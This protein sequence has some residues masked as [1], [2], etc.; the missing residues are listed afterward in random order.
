[1][2]INYIVKIFDHMNIKGPINC[3]EQLHVYSVEYTC[4]HQ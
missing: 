4:N 2:D 3:V 1:M